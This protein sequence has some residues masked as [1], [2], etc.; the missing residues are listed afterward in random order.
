M[1]GATHGPVGTCD[2]K[3]LILFAE[4]T[5]H[6]PLPYTDRSKEDANTSLLR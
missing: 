6:A 2:A 1:T 5:A 3:P 4:V